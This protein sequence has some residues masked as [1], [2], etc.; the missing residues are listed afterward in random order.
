MTIH[1][2]RD[3]SPKTRNVNHMLGLEKNGLNY[4]NKTTGQINQDLMISA[5]IMQKTSVSVQTQPLVFFHFFVV[6]FNLV[7][8]GF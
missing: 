2:I 5:A 4:N 1:P 7:T 6:I 8:R 3:V